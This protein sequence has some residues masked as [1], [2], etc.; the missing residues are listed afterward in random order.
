MDAAKYRRD[1]ADPSPLRLQLRLGSRSFHLRAR[2]LSLEPVVLPQNAGARSGLPQARPGQLVPQVR[3]RAGQRASSGR[4][5]LVDDEAR[6]GALRFAERE[7]GPFL[8]PEGVKRI[9]PL[10]EL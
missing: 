1:E 2:I 10:V 8:R 9:P 7:G 3:H 6:Q 5:L 4:L